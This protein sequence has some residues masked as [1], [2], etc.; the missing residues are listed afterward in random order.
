M[1]LVELLIATSLLAVVMSG[2]VTAF[3]LVLQ[4]SSAADQKITDSTGAQLLTSWLVSDAQSA[5]VV[6]PGATCATGKTVLLELRWT[7]ADNTTGT[8]DVAYVSEDT[9]DGNFRLTRYVYDGSCVQQ[10]QTTVV[11][12]IDPAA[13]TAIC[14]PSATPCADNA[15]QVGLDVTAKSLDPKTDSY[16]SY[17]FQ[18]VGSRRTQ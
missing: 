7:D 9:G 14:T 18:V 17:E 12:D 1:T 4:T 10:R 11:R 16:S 2:I 15:R 13:T 8:T 6:N 3:L 5:D